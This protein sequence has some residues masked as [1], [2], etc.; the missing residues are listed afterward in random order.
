[1]KVQLWML[2][3]VMPDDVPMA[4]SIGQA[5]ATLR[6]GSC[7]NW[8]GLATL[9]ADPGRPLLPGVSRFLSCG[10]LRARE[11]VSPIGQGRRKEHSAR[12]RQ[13]ITDLAAKLVSTAWHRGRTATH[14]PAA[15]TRRAGRWREGEARSRGL[16][17]HLSGACRA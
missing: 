5:W 17:N 9:L 1:M 15:W 16:G 13:K 12:W 8:S 6:T 14:P 7:V 3:N 10:S 2:R 11:P 4:G